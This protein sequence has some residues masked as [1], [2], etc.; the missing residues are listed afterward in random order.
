MYGPLAFLVL[1]GQE[2]FRD[3]LR[4]LGRTSVFPTDRAL[5]DA[6]LE[7]WL[8]WV[9]TDLMPRNERIQEL[10]SNNAHLIHGGSMPLSYQRF[11]EHYHA[12]R[13]RH[14]RWKLHGVSYSWHSS[15]NYPSDELERDATGR[16]PPITIRT[17]ES[18]GGI[19]KQLDPGDTPTA[20]YAYYV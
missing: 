13:V 15:T 11:I 18:I 7:F 1:E 16:R 14:L 12:W 5:T 6:E 10:L 8:F 19:L 4:T 17:A 3:L 2:S 9:D 20:R